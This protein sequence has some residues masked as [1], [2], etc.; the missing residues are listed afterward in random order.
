MKQKA[1]VFIYPAA[2]LLFSLYVLTHPLQCAFCIKKA[3]SVCTNTLIPSLFPFIFA[4]KFLASVVKPSQKS[5]FVTKAVCALFGVN[6]SLMPSVL[7]GLF[8]GF[9]SGGVYA[10]EIYS[11]GLCTKKEAVRAVSLSN[12][13]SAAFLI[14]GA[15]IAVLGKA[16]YG[17]LLV[18]C[19]ILSVI[20]S[21]QILK[22]VYGNTYAKSRFSAKEDKKPINVGCVFTEC[23]KSSCLS[24]LYITG[25]V[26]F[27]YLCA[28]VITDALFPF[29]GEN[30][31]I[32]SALIGAALEISTGAFACS[33]LDFPLNIV[34]C[35]FCVCFP[36][37]SVLF[38]I[39]SV[40]SEHFD[41]FGEY[42]FCHICMALFCAAFAC[43]FLLFFGEPS[44]VSFALFIPFTLSVLSV[45]FVVKK[46][47]AAKRVKNAQ[48]NS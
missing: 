15:G 39:K 30:A 12:N 24:M 9:P 35:A 11:K 18:V 38:Q 19:Q 5:G 40:C 3:L 2:A 10:A 48:K 47:T 42:I 29:L 46:I 6:E 17:V 31:H 23:I 36:S 26:V 43:L 22:L 14:S 20:S 27:F 1:E 41:V 13:C 25:F 4:S 7:I 32:A 37:L 28:S 34:M 16:S 44:H 45:V 21:A 33:G 8:S